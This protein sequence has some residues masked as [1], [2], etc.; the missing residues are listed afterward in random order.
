MST[1][2]SDRHGDESGP[3]LAAVVIAIVFLIAAVIILGLT[4]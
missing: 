4:G 3:A 1:P 2:N